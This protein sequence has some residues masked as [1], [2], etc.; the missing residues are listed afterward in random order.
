MTAIDPGLDTHF[1]S[2]ERLPVETIRKLSTRI[3]EKLPL[4]WFDAMPMAMA[5]VNKHRQILYCN[6]VFRQLAGKDV[7]DEVLGLRPGEALDCINARLEKAGCGCSAFC[8]V[9]N[10]ALAIIKSLD[11]KGRCEECRLL[12]RVH[13]TEVPLDLQVHTNPVE[14][15]GHRLSMIFAMDISHELRLRYLNRTFHHGLING[16]GGITALTELL[17]ADRKDSSLF[18]LLIESSRRT[19]ND[20]VYHKD[21]EAAEN[22]KLTVT[23]TTFDAPSYFNDLIR[24]ECTLKNIQKSCAKV[25][26]TCQTLTTDKRILGHVMRNLLSNALEAR[27]Q[28]P[29]NITLRCRELAD[30]QTAIVMQN[31]GDI[32]EDIQ[33][34]MFK[35]Y[36]STKS[37]DRGLGTYVI[38]LFSERYLDGKVTFSSSN[39]TTTFTILLPKR[40]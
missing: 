17:E 3:Q 11:G 35:R 7:L 24:E 28:A 32:P 13:G 34:Q 6:E 26:E 20:V 22:D 37:R 23:L 25:V 4:A 30:G 31:P 18:E 39:G 5:L 40:S 10:A 21:I 27:E 33:K 16:V 1:A 2:P 15:E 14:F 9:C 29:G 19:L 38:K 8:N 12:R 36:I